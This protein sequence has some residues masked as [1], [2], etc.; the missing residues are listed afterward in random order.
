[1]PSSGTIS[2]Y[3]TPG[4]PG[5]RL[6]TSAY[7]GYSVPTNYDSM[8]GKLIVSSLDWQGAVNKARRALDEFYIE[9]LPTNIPLHQLIVRDEDF[10]DGKF[11]TNY[12]D[13]KLPKFE[14]VNPDTKK[15]IENKLKSIFSKFLF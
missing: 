4:G 11:T 5:V 10:I 9:G 8:I 6:D 12:L 2:A 7:A 13:E 1:M 14:V 3:L 15:E